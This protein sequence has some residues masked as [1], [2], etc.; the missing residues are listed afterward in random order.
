MMS[1]ENF[2]SLRI[3]LSH[4]YKNIYNREACYKIF[5]TLEKFLLASINFL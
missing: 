2:Y 1:I 5:I 3:K 4:R